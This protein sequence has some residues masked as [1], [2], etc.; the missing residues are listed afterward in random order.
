MTTASVI[1]VA[2]GQGRR[3]GLSQNKVYLA[4]RGR[5]LLQWAV[6]AFLN[7]PAIKQVVVVVAEGEIDLC[8][9]EVIDRLDSDIPIEVC[10][11]GD[12]RQASVSNGLQ[13]VDPG[14]PIVLIHDGARPLVS[15]TL[16]QAVID[17]AEVDGAVVPGLPI[18]DSLKQVDEYDRIVAAPS[19]EYLYRAQTPQGFQYN[20]IY[21]ALTK[22][23]SEQQQ[24]T[25]DAGAVAEYMKIQPRL[26]PGESRNIKVTTPADL[27]LAHWLIQQS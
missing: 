24:F 22:A 20:A 4:L 8:Q 19:R 16:I 25:D 5:P 11:G 1:V 6:E 2:A 15:S 13:K 9:Q 27:E 26:I 18:T 10:V 12:H 3:M 17:A 21:Q 14:H 7:C 23:E